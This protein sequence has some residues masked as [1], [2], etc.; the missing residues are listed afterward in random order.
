ML[1]QLL[2]LCE[3]TRLDV[4]SIPEPRMYPVDD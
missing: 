2:E 3:L 4:H 1:P